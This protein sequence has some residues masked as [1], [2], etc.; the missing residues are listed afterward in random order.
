MRKIMTVLDILIKI[1]DIKAL[2][3]KLAA[4]SKCSDLDE[5][6]SKIIKDACSIIDNYINELLKK[7]VK[8]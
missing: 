2:N 1:D 7:E 4:V 6:E 8:E 5:N 3:Y